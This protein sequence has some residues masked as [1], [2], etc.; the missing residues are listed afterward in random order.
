MARRL[1]S[2]AHVDLSPSMQSALGTIERHGP[3]TAGTFARHEQISKPTATR[4]IAELI[5][6]GLVE[7]APD[8]LDG[9]VSWLTLS[10][11]GRRLVVRVRRRYDA[12]LAERVKALPPDEL[13]TLARATDILER[14]TDEDGHP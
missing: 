7:R 13:A 12:F 6:R 5:E 2:E 3:I 11:E 14:L 10:A 8:P 4:T 1:R 9:R